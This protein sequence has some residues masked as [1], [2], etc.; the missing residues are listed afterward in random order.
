MNL[1]KRRLKWILVNHAI[2]NPKMYVRIVKDARD[3]VANARKR[4]KQNSFFPFKISEP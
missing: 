4:K 3:V 1:L 2:K